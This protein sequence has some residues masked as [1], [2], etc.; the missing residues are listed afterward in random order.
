M[1]GSLSLLLQMMIH[2]QAM[3]ENEVHQKCE[4]GVKNS[5]LA[6]IWMTF[7]SLN[8][9]DF[10]RLAFWWKKK[11]WGQMFFKIYYVVLK[12]TFGNFL[13]NNDQVF[14]ENLLGNTFKQY[15]STYDCLLLEDCVWRSTELFGLKKVSEVIVSSH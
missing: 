2:V 7:K 1:T 10:M 14:H 12:K 6:N 13:K 8:T 15:C 9:S 3:T 5:L 4:Q 11:Q